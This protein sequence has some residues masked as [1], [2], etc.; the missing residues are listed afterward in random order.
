[1]ILKERGI[2]MND[3]QDEDLLETVLRLSYAA[4]ARNSGLVP[5]EMIEQAMAGLR[6]ACSG[7]QI[8]RVKAEAIQRVEREMVGGYQGNN[9]GANLSAMQ[10]AWRR[11][12]RVEVSEDVPEVSL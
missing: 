4:Y 8:Q 2:T 11:A 10:R 9:F 1:M 7:A 6:M 5:G 3:T 12:I